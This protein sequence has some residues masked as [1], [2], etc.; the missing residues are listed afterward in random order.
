MYPFHVKFYS[1]RVRCKNIYTSTLRELI[2]IN[3]KLNCYS[4]GYIIYHISESRLIPLELG[5]SDYGYVWSYHQ[6][7]HMNN[8]I[9]PSQDNTLLFNSVISLF[10]SFL[11]WQYDS[12]KTIVD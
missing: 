12:K 1:P 6:D 2:M 8:K 7:S 4:L 5:P 11:M 3:R 9:E 10:L